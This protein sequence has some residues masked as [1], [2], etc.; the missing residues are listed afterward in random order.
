MLTK[1][2]KSNKLYRNT[3]AMMERKISFAWFR[4]CATW[5]K[6]MR[7]GYVYSLRS[8]LI[9]QTEWCCCS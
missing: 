8:V 4:E 6:H 2:R 5:C 1:L 9:D 7:A 3:N